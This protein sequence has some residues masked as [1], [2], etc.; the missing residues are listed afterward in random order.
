MYQGAGDD[1]KFPDNTVA[2]AQ[3]FC[4]NVDN[5]HSQPVCLVRDT[6]EECDIPLCHSEGKLYYTTLDYKQQQFFYSA[7]TQWTP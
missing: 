2:D 4:R 1:D 3:N 5:M 7:G 6:L